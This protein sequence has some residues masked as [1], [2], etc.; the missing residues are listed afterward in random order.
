M[1][2]SQGEKLPFGYGL[3]WRDYYTMTY[4]AYVIPFNIL[5][6]LIRELYVQFS[7]RMKTG[8]IDKAYS[9]GYN[10]GLNS[11]RVYDNIKK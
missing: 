1:K 8:L 2:I 10:D 5:F 3:A 6:R 7:F 4:K 9:K 11:K